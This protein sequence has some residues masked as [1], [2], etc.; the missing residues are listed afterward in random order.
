MGRTAKEPQLSFR[1]ACSFFLS[2]REP[3]VDLT[4]EKG[5]GP[6]FFCFFLFFYFPM[7]RKFVFSINKN[8]EDA[9]DY[10]VVPDRCR[11]ILTHSRLSE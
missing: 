4:I 1:C 11:R 5:V 8:K 9:E 6:F 3:Y 10:H 7:Q 2:S